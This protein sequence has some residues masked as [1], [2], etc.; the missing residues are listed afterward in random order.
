MVTRRKDP[1]RSRLTPLRPGV[2]Q[3]VPQMPCYA[4]NKTD[5]DERHPLSRCQRFPFLIVVEA[6]RFRF[7]DEILVVVFDKRRELLLAELIEHLADL[8]GGE[9]GI[10]VV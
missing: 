4:A 9:A 1:A 8:F 5:E 6:K 7:A 10:R 2:T 3:R